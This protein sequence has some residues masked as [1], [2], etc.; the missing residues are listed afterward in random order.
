MA[1]VSKPTG[2][3]PKRYLGGADW[4]GKVNFYSIDSGD[5]NAYATG[6][7]VALSGTG[8]T[9]GIPGVTLGTAGNT[10]VGVIVSAGGVNPGGGP[11]LDPNNLNTVKIPATK[12]Q[13]YYVAVVDDPQVIFE[14]QEVNGPLAVTDIGLNANFQ[15]NA[16]ANA[17]NAYSGVLLNATG[18]ATTSTLN[19]KIIRLV[20][21]IDN[22]LGAFAK[23][24][25][26]INNHAYRAGITGV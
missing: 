26:L 4:D 3:T 7:P 18:K 19:L 22:A 11:Y 21:R 25:V 8:S 20:Q 6:D 2:L 5:G 1:N 9:G 24:E 15:Y 13:N 17:V 16:P 10:I 23:W 14:I 12:T